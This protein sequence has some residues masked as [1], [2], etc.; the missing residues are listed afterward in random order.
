LLFNLAGDIVYEKTIG[1]ENMEYGTVANAI[2]EKYRKKMYKK[3]QGKP[4]PV[5]LIMSRTFSSAVM[6]LQ[7]ISG[8]P[9]EKLA[10][11]IYNFCIDLEFREIVKLFDAQLELAGIDDEKFIF[12]LHSFYNDVS[13]K[14]RKEGKYYEFAEYIGMVARLH[15]EKRGIIDNRIADAYLSLILQTLEYLRINKFD[16]NSCAYGVSTNGELLM[17][18]Y[19]LAYSD[20][21]AI[22]IQN[23]VYNGK[24]FENR[25]E[26]LRFMSQI[27]AKYGFTINNEQDLSV[28]TETQK[29]HVLTTVSLFPFIN[30]FTFDIVPQKGYSSYYLPLDNMKIDNSDTDLLKTHL[31]KRIRTLPTNGVVFK[32]D[33]P[34]GEISEILMREIL[35]HDRIFML[36]R[37]DTNNGSLA[38]YYDTKDGFFFSVMEDASTDTPFKNLTCLI[39]SLYASQVLPQTP[40]LDLNN[41]FLQDGQP[42]KI[43]AYG[44]GGK[45]QNQYSPGPK[46]T[47]PRPSLRNSDDYEKEDRYINVIIRKLPVGQQASEEAKQLASQYGYELEPGQT[48]VRPFMKQ[49]FVKKETQPN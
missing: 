46:S 5:K 24:N 37:I 26:A 43:K 49:V 23:A 47:S 25:T 1:G 41:K 6:I 15:R 33:D 14:I 7:E 3:M 34:S 36:Y 30:E 29:I 9:F 32:V 12:S 13:Y 2:G 19:P 8:I 10:F 38:G 44:R 11:G 20:L 16:L 48:F 40:S 45:L 17:G 27:Y 39:L 4:N 31:Q 28:L 21:P 22:E 35:H 18:V 42:L